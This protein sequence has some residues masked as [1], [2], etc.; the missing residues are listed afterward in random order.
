ML[1]YSSNGA[2]CKSTLSSFQM[3]SEPGKL[4][5]TDYVCGAQ[6]VKWAGV[7]CQS[8]PSIF[9]DNT[10]KSLGRRFLSVTLSLIRRHHTAPADHNTL[11]ST[12]S[13]K[14]TSAGRKRKAKI[15]QFINFQDQGKILKM[16]SKFFERILKHWKVTDDWLLEKIYTSDF[17]GR[18]QHDLT[19]SDV[20]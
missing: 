4:R 18:E 5:M 6:R 17:S 2:S 14:S 7:N 20:K 11:P 13:P 12:W 19:L 10:R 1:N 16:P 8:K 3:L 15:T 9:P